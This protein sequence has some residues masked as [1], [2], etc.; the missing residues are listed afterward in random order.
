MAKPHK[1][2]PLTWERLDELFHVDPDLGLLIWKK[3]SGKKRM[4]GKI[5][6][7]LSHRFGYI[8]ICIDYVDYKRHRLIWFYVHRCWPI[9][10]DH[11]NGIRNEDG[12]SNLR[13]ASHSQ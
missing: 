8:C 11:I 13:E 5:A 2:P 12:I 7:D 10:L 3:D 6:G 9:E 4:V 1:N